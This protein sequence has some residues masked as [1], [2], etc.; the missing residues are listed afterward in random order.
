MIRKME[1]KNISK[2]IIQKRVDVAEACNE[3]N[4]TKNEAKL[5]LRDAIENWKEHVK[6]LKRRLSIRFSR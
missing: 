3:K 2:G 5:K 4:I 1:V 6:K